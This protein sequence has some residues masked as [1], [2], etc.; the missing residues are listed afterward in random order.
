MRPDRTLLV[1]ALAA[2]GMITGATLD[3]AIKQ[4]PARHDIGVEAYSAY[5][6]AA[7]LSQG[8]AWY[9]ALGAGTALLT[10][11]TVFIALRATR[12]GRT[13]TALWIAGAATV[14]YMAVTAFAAPLNFS[15]R[16]A[17]NAAELADVFDRFALLNAVR[18]GLMVV[19]LAA[20]A[21]VLLAYLRSGTLDRPRA[22]ART[23][24]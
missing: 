1:L 6:R 18:A 3:Q 23:R 10:L 11:V 5:S 15:Q 19:V 13:R 12:D 21:T 20:V 9:G 16:D 22:E 4:L 7:D 8:V 14:G 24:S 2:N 17:A